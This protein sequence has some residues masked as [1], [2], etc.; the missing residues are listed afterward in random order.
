MSRV[1]VL[2][3]SKGRLIRAD[4]E[5][6]GSMIDL[7]FGTEGY[8]PIEVINV[9]NYATGQAEVKLDRDTVREQVREWIADNEQEWPG[10]YEG[11]LGATG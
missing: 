11:Y 8:R 1:H 2:V 7:S 3:R 9:Y 10:W 4:Y 5:P 6:G